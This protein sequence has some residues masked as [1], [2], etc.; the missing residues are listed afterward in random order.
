VL[1]CE[2]NSSTWQPQVRLPQSKGEIIEQAYKASL[3][4]WK[5]GKKRQKLTVLLPLI[6]ATILDD[7]PGGIRQESQAA[8]PMMQD[9]LLRL[10][11]EDGL[12]G[13][14]RTETWDDG[15]AV[16]CW[17]SPNLAL[18]LFLTGETLK[19]AK[20][21]AEE[22]EDRLLLM[23]NPQWQGGQLL[24]DLGVGPWKRRNEEFIATFEDTYVLKR[25]RISGDNVRLLRQY[26]G[27]W[28]IFLTDLEGQDMCLGVQENEPS[29]KDL[30][31][32][33]KDTPTS[34]S[35]KSLSERLQAEFEFNR[36]SIQPPK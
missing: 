21:L 22:T 27:Q 5:D 19:K 23:V 4:A 26:P 33:L 7:W 16:G 20:Q 8:S 2:C 28:N 12:Q 17:K 3:A 18:M 30:Q 10:K 15:D 24:S 34:N 14:L 11:K 29:Y 25:L 13:S 32:L 35:S 9:L 6:G 1:A 36:K 31:R